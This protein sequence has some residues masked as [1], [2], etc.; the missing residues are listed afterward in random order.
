MLINNT[1]VH[2]DCE[3]ILGKS[4]R[5]SVSKINPVDGNVES[6][7]IVSFQMRNSEKNSRCKTKQVAEKFLHQIRK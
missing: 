6:S 4:E 5:K 2:V 3:K 1:E 7:S